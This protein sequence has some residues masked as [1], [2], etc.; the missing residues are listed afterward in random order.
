M[1]NAHSGSA[2]LVIRT[3]QDII[4]AIPYLLGFHP[5][6]SL[7]AIGC[8]GPRGTCALRF[9]L[10][11]SGQA[12]SAGEY[13]ATVL[14]R[15]QFTIVLLAG[16][17]P[18]ARVTPVMDATRDALAVHGIEVREA[19]RIEDGRFWSYLCADQ[20]CCPVGGTPVEVGALAARAV[21]D[22][23][24]AFTDRA[25]LEAT[26][27]PLDGP[28]REAMRGATRWAEDRVFDLVGEG[29]PLVRAMAGRVARGDPPPSDREIAM[30]GIVLTS[31]RVRDEAWVRIDPDRLQPHL[32]FWR[33]VLI[34]V[35]P[36]YVPAPACL[37][38]YS[39]YVLGNGSLANVALT[40]AARADPAYTMTELIQHAVATGLHPSEAKIRIT[41][42]D[43]ALAYLEDSG[44]QA[45]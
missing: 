18:G 8:G 33:E 31:L 9:D 24:V 26:V 41:P 10:P 16:Y 39:A 35:E 34:R 7:V 14:A 20:A 37:L 29:L 5:A 23:R 30:L 42:E 45:A 21:V 2:P 38:A 36:R 43:L 19:L 25:S 3:P 11:H 13:L 12:A 44:S 1:N 6:D 22:G 28:V 4:S 17:G 27:A 15:N 40:R 32:D